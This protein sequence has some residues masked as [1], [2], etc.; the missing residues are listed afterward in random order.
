MIVYL[1]SCSPLV[2]VQTLLA[3]VSGCIPWGHAEFSKQ[4]RAVL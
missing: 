1:Y 2:I 4:D 3:E